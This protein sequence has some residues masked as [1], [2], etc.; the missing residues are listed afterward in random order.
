LAIVLAVLQIYF[1]FTAPDKEVFRSSF[2]FDQG[3]N[4][5]AIVTPSFDLPGGPGN[6]SVTLYAPVQ[7]DWV[8][9]A[10]DL[11]DENTNKSI[12][13]SQTAEYY[14]GRDGGESW[15][16]GSQDSSFILDSIP[17]GRYH[18]VIQPHADAARA[19]EKTFTLL[20]RRGVVTWS[21][22]FTALVLLS[23][24]PFWVWYRGRKFELARWSESD[25]SGGGYTTDDE[26]E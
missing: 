18:L 16:E 15:S 14:F 3:G 1:V 26:G 22:F 19:G 20:L 23:L 24:Y 6:L 4:T 11:V 2:T 25:L 21:N 10:I 12:G 8:E 9:T 7:N 5:R 17:G 13:F